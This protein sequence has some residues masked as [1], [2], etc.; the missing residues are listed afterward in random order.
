MSTLLDTIKNYV[1]FKDVNED[2]FI[3]KLFHKGTVLVLIL[4]SIIVATE[5]F[6]GTP[7]M[8][9]EP[10]SEVGKVEHGYLEKFLLDDELFG[11]YHYDHDHPCLDQVCQ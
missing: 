6:G 9:D 3:C 7:I 11:Q 4:A 2:N 5:Q 1:S 10:R 8:C